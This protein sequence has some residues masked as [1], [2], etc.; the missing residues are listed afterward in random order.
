M[1]RHYVAVTLAI[2]LSALGTL[3]PL[4]LI[5]GCAR[6]PAGIPVEP[7]ATTAADHAPSKAGATA[8]PG[9]EAN[10][11]AVAPIEYD[12]APVLLELPFPPYPPE[13]RAKGIE[14]TV[15]IR[16]LVGVDGKVKDAFVTT[17][18]DPSF[19]EAA[20]ASGRQATFKPAAK[21]GKPVPVWVQLPIRF[22]LQ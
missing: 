12:E 19:D 7:P 21:D 3:L 18:V 2:A 15:I 20:L 16:M 9:A 8:K 13:A 6:E 17:P 5:T 10:P 14:G 1:N 11:A 22:A 4:Q